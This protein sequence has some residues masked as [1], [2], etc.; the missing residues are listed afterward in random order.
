MLLPENTR[1]GPRMCGG[2]RGIALPGFFIDMQ[3]DSFVY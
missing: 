3:A 1:D 2:A